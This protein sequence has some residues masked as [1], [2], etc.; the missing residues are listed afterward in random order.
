M[1]R[2]AA[3][4]LLAL[5][6]LACGKDSPTSPQSSGPR[7]PSVAGTYRSSTMFTGTLTQLST[8]QRIRVTCNGSVTI[9]QTGSRLSGS[10]LVEGCSTDA[11]I[12]GSGTITGTLQ[13]DGGVSLRGRSGS[14][15]NNLD[16]I[17]AAIGCATIGADSAFSGRIS[18]RNLNVEANA[19]VQ[20]I[21]FGTL[22][23][24]EQWR[25]SR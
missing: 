14:G 10:Y 11:S 5:S 7:Y 13:T 16:A 12:V 21:Q 8:G 6:V 24:R 25:G 15:G 9:Q 17:L 23:W 18:G 19:T 2:R 4:V 20:C 3:I 22:T 1:F